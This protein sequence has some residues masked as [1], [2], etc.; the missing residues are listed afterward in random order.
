MRVHVAVVILE[1]G[2][3]SLER[4]IW[5]ILVKKALIEASLSEILDPNGN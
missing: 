2:R 3:Q 5:K 4:G 1:I